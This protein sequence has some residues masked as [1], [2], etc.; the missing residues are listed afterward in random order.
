MKPIHKLMA[1]ALVATFARE[2]AA[3]VVYERQ[4]DVLVAAIKSGH[5]EGVLKGPADAAFTKQ[6]KST[7]P[8]RV[9]ADLIKKYPREGCARVHVL[10]TKPNVMGP[11]GLTDVNLDTK[12]NYC[13]DGRPPINL[14]DKK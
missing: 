14:E 13:L 4:H 11:K 1:M 5:A 12:M 9:K 10:Y 3:Q 8:L 2:S 7:A 6:F